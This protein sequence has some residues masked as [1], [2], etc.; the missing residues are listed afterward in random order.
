MRAE[1]GATCSAAI[2]LASLHP[3][4]AAGPLAVP[5]RPFSIRLRVRQC[6]W[7]LHPFISGAHHEA[8][9]RSVIRRYTAL[10]GVDVRRRSRLAEG[11]GG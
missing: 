11:R 5:S 10:P 3:T 7:R 8:A 4:P 9:P 1:C 2:M 6:I